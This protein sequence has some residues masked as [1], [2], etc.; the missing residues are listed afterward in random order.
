MT[1]LVTTL[2][3]CSTLGSLAAATASAAGSGCGRAVLADWMDGRIEGS[4]APHCYGDAIDAL[5]EDVR[6]YTTAEGDIARALQARMRA[7]R[8]EPRSAAPAPVDDGGATAAT[9]LPLP[10][11]AAAALTVL[12]GVAGLAAVVGRRLRRI[13]LAHR[14]TRP[15]G[16]H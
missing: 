1:K 11:L 8:P 14:R 7:V 2:A 5:P 3:L 16:Q 6:A 15:L 4:Y 13:R 12:L 10:L 9:S